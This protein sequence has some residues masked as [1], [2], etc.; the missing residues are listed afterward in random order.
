MLIVSYDISNDKLRTRFSKFLTKF[1]F[2][3]QYSVYQIKNSDAVLRNVATEIETEFSKQFEQT[4]S[5]IIFRLSRQC[6]KYCYGYAI[7]D[8]D[9]LIIIE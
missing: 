9:E 1:G 5:V 6:K 4:D 3:L 2:R 7:N 8:N